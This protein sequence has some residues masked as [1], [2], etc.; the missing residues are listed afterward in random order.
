M[1]NNNQIIKSMDYA[2]EFFESAIQRLSLFFLLI[3][4]IAGT[5]AFLTQQ[6]DLPQ[7]PW[8]ELSWATVQAVA[9]DGLFFGVLVRFSKADW[10]AHPWAKSYYG[11][12]AVLLGFVA[13]VVSTTIT[14]HGI[15]NESVPQALASIG[16]SVSAFATA[17]AVIVVIVF[18]LVATLPKDQPDIQEEEATKQ[19]PQSEAL[20]GLARAV[21][22]LATKVTEEKQLDEGKLAVEI[23]NRQIR[24]RYHQD[25]E[26]EVYEPDHAVPSLSQS[27]PKP[28]DSGTLLDEEDGREKDVEKFLSLMPDASIR[29]IAS[30]LQMSKSSV[31]R[32]VKKIREEKE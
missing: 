25:E 13:A 21:S 28:W 6:F 24:Y 3:G 7:S 17:R 11:L 31:Q 18:A 9:V 26:E 32:I 30:Q 8:F 14:A 1:S 15:N 12:V 29:F 22:L 19:D 23:A 27:C 10:K 2:I 20:A 16:I 5:I 4:F